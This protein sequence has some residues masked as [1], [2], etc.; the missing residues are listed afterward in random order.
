MSD[1]VPQPAPG[2]KKTRV[3]VEPETG[4]QL[5]QF[6]IANATAGAT[7]AEAAEREE[8]AKSAVKGYL[9]S[10]FPDP[11]MLPDA[12]DIAG[13][14]HGRYPPMTLVLK[15]GKRFDSKRFREAA[16]D[17]YEAY[18]VEIRPS[19]VLTAATRGR[20]RS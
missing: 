6:L 8:E 20:R 10:L 5:E 2:R 16:P 9:L 13:D 17:V 15:G 3:K 7:A 12:F 1:P 4:G 11:S 18:E 14:P 19:W